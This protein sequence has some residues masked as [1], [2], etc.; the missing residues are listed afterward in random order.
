[1]TPGGGGG[2]GQQA[3]STRAGSVHSELRDR[4]ANQREMEKQQ[5]QDIKKDDGVRC[6]G[7]PRKK[8]VQEREN[9]HLHPKLQGEVI[10]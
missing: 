2:G 10:K 3:K 5:P 6:P 7:P 8:V 1:M 9:N 4:E